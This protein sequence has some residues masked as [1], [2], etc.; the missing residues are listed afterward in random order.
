M[1]NSKLFAYIEAFFAVI[2]WGASFVATKISLQYLSPS[3]V[4]WLRFSMGIV[5]L[6]LAAVLSKQFSLPRGRDWGYFAALGLL[7]ITFHQ[8][9]QSNALETSQA[10]TSAWIVST[11]P[12]F[13]AL[14][15]WVLLKES[16]DWTKTAGILLAFCGVLVIVS[17]GDWGLIAVGRFGASGDKLMLVSAIT[18]A[19]FSAFS[20]R[21][22]KSQPANLMMFYVMF[23]GWLFTSL[24]FVRTKSLSEIGNLPF[25]GWMSIA[26]LGI[27]CSGLAYIAWYG[28]LKA[29]GTA[30]TGA[31]LYIEPLVTVVVAFFILGE[32]LTFASWIGGIIILFGIWLVNRAGEADQVQAAAET[33]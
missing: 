33:D 10:G 32:A 9:L 19:I 8:W 21:G 3:T 26:F 24:L 1:S 16:L 15:G 4:V 30:Q 28:A 11:S 31:F 22:L 2:V 12:V 14:L 13:M 23:F 29:L 27:F 7:G 18:W 6:G 5:I 20:R 17:K 25:N